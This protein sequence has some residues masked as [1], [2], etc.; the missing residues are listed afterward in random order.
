VSKKTDCLLCA[1][2]E[3]SKCKTEQ[4]PADALK[5][6]AAAEYA[7]QRAATRDCDYSE[8]IE[9]CDLAIAEIRSDPSIRSLCK[10]MDSRSFRQGES[11]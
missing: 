7:E 6:V 2:Q 9:E 8:D 5:G 10:P 11:R 3:N 1:K 4:D